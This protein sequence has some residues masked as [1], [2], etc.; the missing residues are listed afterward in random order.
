MKRH[1]PCS[2]SLVPSHSPKNPEDSVTQTPFQSNYL[3]PE[4]V[5]ENSKLYKI[6]QN[7]ERNYNIFHS[8][9]PTKSETG[10]LTSVHNPH[11][12]IQKNGSKLATS[13]L[14]Y[15]TRS[16]THN[17][18]NSAVRTSKD[19]QLHEQDLDSKRIRE[20]HLAERI[21]QMLLVTPLSIRKYSHEKKLLPLSQKNNPFSIFKTSRL[22]KS[23][24]ERSSW[25]FTQHSQ[26]LKEDP[27]QETNRPNLQVTGEGFINQSILPK[28]NRQ[29]QRLPVEKAEHGFSRDF[30]IGIHYN[31]MTGCTQEELLGGI[32]SFKRNQTLESLMAKNPLWASQK[33]LIQ[34]N[35]QSLNLKP[36]N[37]TS[38]LATTRAASPNNKSSR[39]STTQSS[40]YRKPNMLGKPEPLSNLVT[41]TSFSK[42]DPRL[43]GVSG[44]LPKEQVVEFRKTFNAKSTTSRKGMSNM[45][46]AVVVDNPFEHFSLF[47]IKTNPN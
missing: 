42:P 10:K 35:L 24:K 45:Q 23:T 9:L 28:K 41:R 36:A 16:A 26:S 30:H 29:E 31:T 6:R 47:R 43:S 11:N 12:S 32:V 39:K 21:P 22:S 34:N 46:K 33:E 44:A 20:E 38:L 40:W 13:R 18:P 4:I 3:D 37:E 17:L 14:K 15:L 5:K 2:N 1:S 27:R 7:Y 25:M 19:D 8:M